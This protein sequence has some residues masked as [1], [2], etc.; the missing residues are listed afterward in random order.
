MKWSVT[1]VVSHI[2]ISPVVKQI[3]HNL[4]VT[5][6]TG[7][8]QGSRANIVITSEYIRTLLK[9]IPHDLQVTINHS[10]LKRCTMIA[11]T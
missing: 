2:P 10:K 1:I 8:M 9:Q 7:M 11:I 5:K 6:M 3:L 4:F